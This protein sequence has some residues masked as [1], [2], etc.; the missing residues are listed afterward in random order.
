MSSTQTQRDE[1]DADVLIVGC[2]PVGVMAALRSVQRGLS[3]IAI[4]RSTEVYPLP[5]A[6]GMDDEVQ[7]VFQRAGLID[8]LR[9]YSTPLLGAEFVNASGERVVGIDVPEG[10][11]GPLGLPPIVMFDQP[12]VETFLRGAAVEAGVD[13]RLGIDAT[14]VECIGDSVRLHTTD[15]SNRKI[16]R[17]RWLVAADGAKSTI[18]SLVG[19]S[20]VDQG[21]DQTWLVVDTTLKDPSVALPSVARQQCD[22]RRICTLVPG[23]G[24]RRRWEFQLR[25]DE[26]REDVLAEERIAEFLSPWG[27]PDQLQVDRAAVYRFHATVAERFRDGPVFLAGDSAHQ[28]PPFNG[29]GMCTGIRDAENLSWKFAEVA[30]GAAGDTLLD[31][32]DAE[33]RPHAAG[34]VEH[35]AD[36]GRLIQAIAH[37]GEA[38]LDAGYGQRPFPQLEYGLIDGDHPFVGRPIPEP[39]VSTDSLGEGW[40]LIRAQS[41]SDVPTFWEQCNATVVDAS[42]DAYPDMLDR[43]VV[44]VVRPDRYVA[45]VTKDLP[46]ATSRLAEKIVQ[47]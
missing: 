6:I 35:A 30:K 15:G 7:Q 9:Q 27:S 42:P 16:L 11:L 3:V 45:A 32:Y 1:P 21:F 22:P 14:K 10:T 29:Q 24:T 28:M 18:R 44:I 8:H 2:G 40:N 23:H 41:S 17:G 20:M 13:L 25:P 34:Q 36:A 19:I 47:P 33:R 31:S 43:D 12:A 37:D 38:A 5:R 26:V 39:L 4:D 46:A